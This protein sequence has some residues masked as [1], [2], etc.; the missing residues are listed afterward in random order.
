MCC[1]MRSLSQKATSW[2]PLE[3]YARFIA[4]STPR[5]SSGA[6][7]FT[8][9]FEFSCFAQLSYHARVCA[10]DTHLFLNDRLWVSVDREGVLLPINNVSLRRHP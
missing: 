5:I 4:S 1:P 7:G 8:V 3:H 2:L 9:F 6:T 10:V